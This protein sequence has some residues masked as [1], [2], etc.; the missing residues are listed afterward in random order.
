MENIVIG[1]K[2]LAQLVQEVSFVHLELVMK[3]LGPTRA[4]VEVIVQVVL[5]LNVL[6][7][8]TTK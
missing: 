2:T 4:L 5:K 3:Q 7:V 6:L 8:P 1:V